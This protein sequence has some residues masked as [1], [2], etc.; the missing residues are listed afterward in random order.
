[1]WADVATWVTHTRNITSKEDS[2]T[3]LRGM[4]IFQLVL[5]NVDLE[6]NVVHILLT[7]TMDIIAKALVIRI[8]KQ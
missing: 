4:A 6:I 5:V 1:M 7:N 8:V 3:V 2:D